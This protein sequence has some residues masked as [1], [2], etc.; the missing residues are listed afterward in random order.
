M[1]SSAH[2]L[3]FLACRDGLERIQVPDDA[4]V[5][6]LRK[7]ISAALKVPMDDIALSRNQALVSLQASRH[8]KG[9]CGSGNQ[10]CRRAH[11]RDAASGGERRGARRGS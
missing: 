9:H 7:H 2:W 3:H 11:T 6:A 1:S 8:N 5:A 4:T 10:C